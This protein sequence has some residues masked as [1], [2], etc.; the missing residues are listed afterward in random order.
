[1]TMEEQV[2]WKCFLMRRDRDLEWLWQEEQ[3][4]KPLGRKFF[5]GFGQWRQ[6][7]RKAAAEAP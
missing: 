2:I 7:R 4:G 5:T 1:M 6:K 3:A